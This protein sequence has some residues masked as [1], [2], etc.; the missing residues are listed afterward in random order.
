MGGGEV[1]NMT[2]IVERRFWERVDQRQTDECWPWKGSRL[3]KD[4]RGVLAISGRNVTAPRVA[5]FVTHRVWP[6]ADV[7]VCHSCDNPM[8]VNPRHLWLGN[9][10]DNLKDAARKHRLW[11]QHDSGRIRGERHGNSKLTPDSVRKIRGMVASGLSQR[12]V[13]S[14]FNISQYAV[15]AI[16]SRRRWSHVV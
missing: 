3:K 11:A 4:G 9:S 15:W 14:H 10:S 2:D 13:A 6:D 16:S 1:T 5:W 8:C 7:F 12:I